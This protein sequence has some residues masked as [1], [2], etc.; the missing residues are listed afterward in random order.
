MKTKIDILKETSPLPRV[1]LMDG[2]WICPSCGD[3]N[4]E[5]STGIATCWNCGQNVKLIEEETK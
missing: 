3:V 4:A 1:A 2:L 5:D